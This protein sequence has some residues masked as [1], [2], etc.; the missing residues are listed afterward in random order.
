VLRT[1]YGVVGGHMTLISVG[2]IE[3]GQDAWERICA[4]AS[5]V[6][7]YTSFVWGGPLTPKRINRALLREVRRRSLASIE[8]AIGRADLSA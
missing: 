8:D 4:G 2:G 3:T 7:I 6:Q 5:L 1:L